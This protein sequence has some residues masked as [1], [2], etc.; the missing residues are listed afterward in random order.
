MK[1]KCYS[2]RLKDLVQVSP[3][4]YKAIAFDGSTAFI[5]ASQ[6]FGEDDAVKNSETYWISAWIL[7]RTELQYSRKKEGWFDEKR[8]LLPSYR[9]ERHVPGAREALPHNEINELRK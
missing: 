7:E 1:T 3:K 8:R 4:A 2:V 6:V 9:V 5:P